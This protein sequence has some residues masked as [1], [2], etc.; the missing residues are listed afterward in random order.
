VKLDLEKTIA[1]SDLADDT[2]RVYTGY[3]R[4][5]LAFAGD[6]PKRWNA[7]ALRRFYAEL[8]KDGVRP[9]SATTMLRGVVGTLKRVGI[10]I[11]PIDV[12]GGELG[13]AEAR[14]GSR[15]LTSERAQALLGACKGTD[16]TA[17]RDWCL[18]IVALYTG[19]RRV[20]LARASI[21]RLSPVAPL[22]MDSLLERALAGYKGELNLQ[23]ARSGA[24][25]RAVRI[26]FQGWPVVGDPLTPSGISFALAQRAKRAGLRGFRVQSLRESHIAWVSG[27]TDAN[28]ANGSVSVGLSGPD[29]QLGSAVYR[30]ISTALGG[31]PKAW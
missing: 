9:A 31:E 22:A 30:A 5:W 27:I 14:I 20:D 23:N 18:V 16:L 28:R 11:P 29:S 26:N 12:G 24:L 7:D 13:G 21:D 6:D 2:K 19:M 15:P 8:R 1:S 4:R 17:R 10:T 3:A 25:F